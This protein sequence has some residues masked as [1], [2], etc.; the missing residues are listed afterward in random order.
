MP[1][2]TCQTEQKSELRNIQNVQETCRLFSPS[3]FSSSKSDTWSQ[4]DLARNVK[5]LYKLLKSC[6]YAKE[7]DKSADWTDNQ[8]TSNTQSCSCICE[9]V[10]SCEGYDCNFILDMDEFLKDNKQ[11]IGE[12]H[13]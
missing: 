2:D 11:F 5:E 7:S 13:M 6:K 3:L 10:C 12:A 1:V 9:D 8:T 4:K